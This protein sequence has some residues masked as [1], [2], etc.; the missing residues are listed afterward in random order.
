MKSYLDALHHDRIV[1]AIGEA[2][3]KTT[4]QIRVHVHHRAVSDPLAAA[5]RV[6]EKLGMTKTADRNGVLVFVA[7]RSKNF[8]IVGDSGIHEKCGDAFWKEAAAAMAER[9]RSGD[10]SDGLVAT[11]EKLGA[12][13]AEHFPRTA[14]GENELPNEIDEG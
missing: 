7:P 8:A 6:F 14:P 11:I 3:K 12:V 5:G 10:F 4:G 2:E 1:A 13:L 9:F